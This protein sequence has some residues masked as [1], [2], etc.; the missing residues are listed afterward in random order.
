LLLAV[1]ISI[2]GVFNLPLRDFIAAL[3]DGNPF[4]PNR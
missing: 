4:S 1:W 3:L 2:L